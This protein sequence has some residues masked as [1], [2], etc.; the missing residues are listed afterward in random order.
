[1]EWIM[2]FVKNIMI[3]SM[4]ITNNLFIWSTGVTLLMYLFI[5]NLLGIPFG[6]ITAEEH[7]VSWWRSPTADA[8][9]TMTLAIMIIVYTH[10]IDIR[11]HGFKHFFLSFF[12]PFK[13]LFPINAV[14]QLATTLTLGLRLFG[15][16]YAGEVML[17]LLASSV[18]QGF[19]VAALAIVPMLIWQAFCIF[20]GVIQ[21]YIFVTLTMVY[22]AHRLT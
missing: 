15:N 13:F 6:I 4:G 9:V 21:A 18:T 11:L 17:T 5:A 7:P 10:F 20:I 8:H 19:V 12:K 3:D 16:I 14:E 22:I 2:E 1:M